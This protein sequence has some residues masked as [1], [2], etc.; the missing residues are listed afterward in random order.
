MPIPNLQAI[1]DQI[2]PAVSRASKSRK[3]DALIEA[4]IK[5]NVSQSAKDIR[6]QRGA[7]PF[8]QR[9]QTDGH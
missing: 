4:A 8:G 3:D 5:E 9:R 1:V 7:A 6:E 2:E